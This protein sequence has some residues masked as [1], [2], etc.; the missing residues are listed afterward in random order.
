MI[1][2]TLI[3]IYFYPD[4]KWTLTGDDYDG[5]EWFDELPKPTKKELDAK[6]EDAVNL[7]EQKKIQRQEAK[8]KLLNQ[9]GLTAD[10]ISALLA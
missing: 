9:L 3:L 6:W 10:E 2:Y 7:R 1:D 5:L 8:E 4:T